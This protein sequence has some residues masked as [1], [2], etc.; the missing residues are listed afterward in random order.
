V[1][2]R[3]KRL[4]PVHG[5][6]YASAASSP[7]GGGLVKLGHGSNWAAIGVGV[8]PYAICALLCSVFVIGYPTGRTWWD[9]AGAAG[10]MSG[11][12]CRGPGSQG[13]DSTPAPR[14]RAGGASRRVT[15]Q[16]YPGRPRP[17]D[18]NVAKLR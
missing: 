18:S 2:V 8:A 4:V 9:R 17:G 5:W 16:R 14:G 12:L 13:D 1:T 7:I 6:L 3:S 10:T 11:P 15:D